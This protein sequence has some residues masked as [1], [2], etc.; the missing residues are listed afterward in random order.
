MNDRLKPASALQRRAGWF[1]VLVLVVLMLST[2]LPYAWATVTLDTARD[3]SAAARITQGEI[4][5]RGPILNGLFHLG[6]VWFYLLA[7]ILWATKSQAMTLLWVGF[8]SSLKFPLAYRLGLRLRDREL[9]LCMA[10]LLGLP[11]WA[12]L[13]AMFPTHTVMVEAMVLAQ[14]LLMLR[15]GQDAG[16]F[17]WAWLGLV[18]GLALHAHPSAN[19]ILIMLPAVFWLRRRWPTPSELILM[20]VGLVLFVLPLAPMLWAEWG[21][22]WPA[23][24]PT[25]EF[26]G[27]QSHV[28]SLPATLAILGGTLLSGPQV[29]L[30]L[31]GAT[32]LAHSVLL[33]MATIGLASALA[34]LASGYRTR[35]LLLLLA[36]VVIASMLSYARTYT[37]F[38]MSLVLWP[39]IACLLALGLTTLPRPRLW[40]L[41]C[42]L[43]A[44]AASHM[45]I[46]SALV[47]SARIDVARLANVQNATPKK[48]DAA[49]LPAWQL[50]AL[51]K[52]LCDADAPIVLHG[53]LAV[54]YDSSL[55]LGP[56]LHCPG[57]AIAAF[58]GIGDTRAQH[59]LGLPPRIARSMGLQAGARWIDTPRHGV[60]PL[61]PTA[62]LPPADRL[63]YPHHQAIGT[64][65]TAQTWQVTSAAGSAIIATDLLYP[66][67]VNRVT[68]VS[69]NGKPARRYAEANITSVWI[70]DQCNEQSIVW[71]LQGN[72]ND[73]ETL[74]IVAVQLPADAF[75]LRAPD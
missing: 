47:G 34:G 12:Q 56:E 73:P 53:Y 42:L 54:L 18:A 7:P 20:C 11:G 9:G 23:L 72:G 62:S 59:W 6:P 13:G 63:H 22:G 55:A 38:Y 68:S 5:L 66:Y 60:T 41:A 3:L 25:L 49:L 14:M 48:V 65:L 61:W 74:E 15:L 30:E 32:L 28:V 33:L 17:N 46:A 52:A 16:H 70:C 10:A 26:A 51:G 27:E 75:Q 67:R 21:E 35:L 58:S 45:L 2:A 31:A 64:E 39:P 19:F 69:A 37:P 71:E 4:V 50:D 36:I 24:A 1:A 8:L 44:L 43:P 40:L 29:A 57:Q